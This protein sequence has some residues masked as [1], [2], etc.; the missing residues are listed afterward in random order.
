MSRY[1][2]VIEAHDRQVRRHG[3]VPLPSGVEHARCHLVV[4]REDGRRC[5]DRRKQ[6]GA[7]CD[8]RLEAVVPKRDQV[9]GESDPHLG[10]GEFKARTTLRCRSEASRS[11]DQADATMSVPYEEPCRF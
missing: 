1:G 5:R 6:R 4:A 11:S 9:G 3:Q 8:A 10:K 2:R 7:G